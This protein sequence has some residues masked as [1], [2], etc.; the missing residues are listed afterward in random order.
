[1]GGETTQGIFTL[2]S[3]E[4]SKKNMFHHNRPAH[5]KKNICALKSEWLQTQTNVFQNIKTLR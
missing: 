4:T 3:L 1:M 2:K 5:D